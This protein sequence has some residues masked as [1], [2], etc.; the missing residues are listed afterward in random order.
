MAKDPRRM[1]LRLSEKAAKDLA[2]L[3]K[4]GEGVK[5]REIESSIRIVRILKEKRRDG[6][7]LVLHKDE[8]EL[9]VLIP[10]I[11]EA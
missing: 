8:E 3:V 9:H 2:W 6:W 11:E 4:H 1:N 5:T 7:K 10:Y